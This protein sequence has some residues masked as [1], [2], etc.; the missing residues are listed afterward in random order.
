MCEIYC[1][2]AGSSDISVGR[3]E[4]FRESWLA[5][6]P[7][8]YL[9]GFSP[10]IHISLFNRENSGE[11]GRAWTDASLCTCYVNPSYHSVIFLGPPWNDIMSVST[12]ILL[13][14]CM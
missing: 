3:G 9:Y 1:L 8:F 2:C 5:V 10:N 7:I 6:L 11:S 12:N 14:L 13:A 4:K